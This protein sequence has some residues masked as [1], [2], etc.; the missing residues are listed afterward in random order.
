MFAFVRIG[1]VP[2]LLGLTLVAVLGC[3]QA[4]LVAEALR[5]G[6]SP[7]SDFAAFWKAG[8]WTAGDWGGSLYPPSS[9]GDPP[10]SPDERFLGFVNP[11]HVAALFRPLASFEFSTASWIVVVINAM[12]L[13]AVLVWVG[14]L[15]HRQKWPKLALV[16]VL[17]GF[18]A[19]PMAAAVLVNGTMTLLVVIAWLLLWTALTVP[20]TARTNWIVAL[21]FVLLSTKPQYAVLPVIALAGMR[22]W[23]LLGAGCSGVV[24]SIAMSFP[25][26]GLQPWAE[27]PAFLSRYATTADLWGAG[28]PEA[29]LVRQM[30][31]VRGLGFFLFGLPATASINAVSTAVLGLA[32]VVVAVL[33]YRGVG[34]S[35]IWPLVFA[36]SIATAQHINVADLLLCL[37]VLVTASATSSGRRTGWTIVLIVATVFT[38]VSRESPTVPWTAGLLIV[39]SCWCLSRCF[40]QQKPTPG[41]TV[42]AGTSA[43]EEQHVAQFV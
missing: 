15:L 10:S 8:R 38:H 13:V 36:L 21:G 11:P 2:Q 12:L 30:P 23:R 7:I 4:L 26:T 9:F 20:P 33:A 22:R 6:F 29:W 40:H 14:V 17:V 25:F 27:Y 16:T 42:D 18:G 35:S 37:V 39:T 43:N 19:S 34:V 1:R 28:E 41:R 32:V 5:V 3:Q 31:S 24:L